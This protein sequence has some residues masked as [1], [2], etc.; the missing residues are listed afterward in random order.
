MTQLLDILLA[1]LGLPILVATG[2]LFILALLARRPAPAASREQRMHF[3]IIVPAHNEE[4]GIERTVQVLQRMEWPSALRR[5]LVVADNCTDRTAE[6]AERAGARVLVRNDSEHRGKG[7]ALEHA[8]RASLA[9]GFAD[10]VVVV[11]ADTEVS[12]NLLTA[13]AAHFEQGEHALQVSNEVLNRTHSWRTGLLT[14]GFALF[15]GVRSLSRDRL[16]LSVG[17]RGN[18]MGLSSQ[19]LRAVPH[20]AH[21]V[22]EDL[23]YGIHLGRAGYRVGYVPE[24]SVR[25]LMPSTEPASRSQRLRWEGG[26][27]ALARKQGAPL[28]KEGLLHRDPL[29]L[30]LGLDLL[31]PP[32]TTLVLAA[33]AGLVL[34]LGLKGLTDGLVLSLFPWGFS[35]TALGVYVLRGWA[36]SGLG[37]WGLRVLLTAAPA[38]IAWKMMLKPGTSGAPRE[39]VRTEREPSR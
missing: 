19:V 24:A 22:V 11:D 29:L 18:G 32:L 27:R 38:Y 25:S 37:L 23:E 3:D 30:D 6:L 31:V 7:Y 8:F 28:V 10:A 33:G 12:P 15:N 20:Q 4:Q 34:A 39:W 21:S 9:D 17:L 2:Y 16:G 14:I 36:L 35:V 1:L 26:R 5:V 13:F